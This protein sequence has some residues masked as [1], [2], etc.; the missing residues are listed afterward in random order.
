MGTLRTWLVVSMLAAQPVWLAAE[1]IVTAEEFAR[2]VS[3]RTVHFTWNGEYFGSE[4]YYRS[5]RA[6]W[7]F[8]SG[9]CQEGFWEFDGG[10]VCF[11]YVGDPERMCWRTGV[12]NG[13]IYATQVEASGEDGITLTE[14]HSDDSD[15]PCPGPLVGS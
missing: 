13:R 6:L 8:A 15:L 14:S 10:H 5:G 9:L 7:R 4:Q 1:P 12:E 2:R 11:S 3:G